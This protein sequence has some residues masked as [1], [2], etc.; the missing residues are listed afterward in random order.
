MKLF[1]FLITLT[2]LAAAAPA[3][4]QQLDPAFTPTTTTGPAGRAYS[5]AVQP[6]GKVLM[7][8]MVTRYEGQLGS[9]L[10]RLNAD[11]SPDTAFRRR[12]GVGGSYLRH[13]RAIALQ[14]DGKIV[15]GG[16]QYFL[17]DVPQPLR[18]NADGSPDA[19][20]RA[21]G[22]P[23]VSGTILA[24]AT[25]PDGKLLVGGICHNA[26]GTTV[27]LERLLPD[28][29][30]DPAFNLGTGFGN[31]SAPGEVHAV[32]VLPN[33]KL[34]VAG[35]FTEVNGYL[36][37]GIV[38]L[39]PDGSVDTSFRSAL[40][41]QNANG[42]KP[43]VLAMA[44]QPL[45]GKILVA[46]TVL[47]QAQGSLRRLLPDGSF[48]ASFQAPLDG[49]LFQV[50]VQASGEV[51]VAGWFGTALGAVRQAV[52]RLH[53]D[54]TP[55]AGFATGGGPGGL[56]WALAELP[57]GSY[58][59]GGDYASVDQQPSPG[60]TRLTPAGRLDP[61]FAPR[62]ENVNTLSVVPLPDGTFHLRGTVGPGDQ[63][64][65]NNQPLPPA[66]Y[67]RLAAD[68][69]Y[70]AS[71]A[72]PTV[73]NNNTRVG[74]P[75]PQPDGTFYHVHLPSGFSTGPVLIDRLLASGQPD[76]GF[77]TD[78]LSYTT[79]GL[80][81]ATVFPQPSGK[82]AVCGTLSVSNNGQ[83]REALAL[84][85]P[86]GRLDR[87][88][89]PPATGLW[90]QAAQT[91]LGIGV[92]YQTGVQSVL[93]Q[94]NGRMLIYWHDRQ[95][96]HLTRLNPDG[97]IDPGFDL[98]SAAGP[99]TLFQAQVLA[100]GQVLLRGSFTSFG[101]QAVANGWLRLLPDG[102][103]DPG[104]A[105]ARAALTLTEQPDGRL[106]AL[107]PGAD[108]RHCTLQRLEADG[109]ADAS[110]Q[111]IAIESE[112]AADASAG[113][114][115]QP[116]D[117]AIVLAGFFTRVAGQPRHSLARLVNTPMLFR[118]TG[119]TA[120]VFPNPVREALHVRL[121]AAATGPAVLLDLRGRVASTWPAPGSLE[122]TLPLT[123]LRP[124]LYFLSVPTAQGTARRRIAVE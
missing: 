116:A 26:A 3:R 55:D 45:D 28:G 123:G 37:P 93:P 94:P 85:Q 40:L 41:A 106:L 49:I 31:G 27:A 112:V 122:A 1:Y 61:G 52:A 53:A 54:G 73:V 50:R 46:G 109:R 76:P 42:S 80:Y 24:L 19:T 92:G 96:S 58:M 113:V 44:R 43:V 5:L 89:V 22:A 18:L 10:V 65:F 84:L 39:L 21:S 11:C 15:Y 105:A 12:A 48:D 32:E 79:P 69:S 101:G 111:A 102:R 62:M 114:Q 95:R 64:N 17:G 38:Q 72:F 7:G 14:A 119:P 90:V 88:F 57:N 6:D 83:P 108:V 25:Q 59:V 110:F 97:S 60:L 124:G 118:S 35:V 9:Q 121:S 29:R 23:W 47:D 71:L 51:L 33:G 77:A 63:L 103:P 13:M 68:G 36:T 100:N 34:L 16:E 91:P 70:Q 115:L 81:G 78:T 104:F 20:F 75:W 2:A 82:I 74:Y 66:Y 30:P 86:N 120:E 99:N 56:V 98:G 87:S 117:Q 8:T 4:A 67:H 107:V